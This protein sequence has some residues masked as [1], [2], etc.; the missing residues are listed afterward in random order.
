MQL[1]KTDLRTGL[2]VTTRKQVAD[3]R[4]QVKAQQAKDDIRHGMPADMFCPNKRHEASQLLD[5]VDR[6]LT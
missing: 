4:S 2:S 5:A 3:K 1:A 6:L